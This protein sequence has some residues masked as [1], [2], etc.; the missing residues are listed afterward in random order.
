MYNSI[1]YTSKYF[2]SYV[3]EFFKERVLFLPNTDKK[4][5]CTQVVNI[6]VN[7]TK[8]LFSA[9]VRTY[10]ALCRSCLFE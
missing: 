9:I 6:F 2:N 7:N 10:V 8:S 1:T 4:K 3:V 5:N